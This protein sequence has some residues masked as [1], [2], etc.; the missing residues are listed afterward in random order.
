MFFAEFTMFTAALFAVF[1]TVFETDAAALVADF[2]TEAVVF[3]MLLVIGTAL[4]VM[5]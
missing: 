5:D 1:R 3:R 4:L 2:A